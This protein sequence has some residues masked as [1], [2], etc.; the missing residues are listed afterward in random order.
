MKI[1]RKNGNHSQ[2]KS[3]NL[4]VIVPYIYIHTH[5]HTHTHTHIFPLWGW[6]IIDGKLIRSN[7]IYDLAAAAVAAAYIYIFE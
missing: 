3:Y 2:N 5:T 1:I 7:Y 6:A 4:D